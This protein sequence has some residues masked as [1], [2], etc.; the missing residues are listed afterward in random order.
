MG[1]YSLRVQ[2]PEWEDSR[3]TT[4]TSYGSD[5][6]RGVDLGS[7]RDKRSKS[8]P[9]RAALGTIVEANLPDLV[10]HCLVADFQ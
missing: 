5:M 6:S 3:G 4:A 10:E 8:F 7:H 1:P 2:Q 9:T